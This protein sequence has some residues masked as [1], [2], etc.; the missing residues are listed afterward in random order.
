MQ[1]ATTCNIQEAYTAF[2]N[3]KAFPC[4]G[5]K[6][7]MAKLQAQSM[8]AGHMACPAHDKA[9]LDFLYDFIDEVRGSDDNFHSA[10]IIFNSPVNMDEDTF[11]M[12]LWQRLQSL[13]KMDAE[14][15]AYDTRV[16]PDPASP[17]FSFSLKSEAFFI[18]GMHPASSRKARRFD[19][20]TLVFNLHAQFERLKETSKYENMQ[21]AIRKKDVLFSGSVNPMLTDHGR[22]SE[23]MQYSGR[24][25][26]DGF[27]CPLK[28]FHAGT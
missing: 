12:L 13:S 19:Y 26:K 22:S 25:Y 20:P 16:S 10:A 24:H 14:R 4:I 27:E 6:A 8:V 21:Q 3:D 28:I 15:Y 23:I 5:A 7:S 9:I 18:I 2:I 1:A 17:D 11:E